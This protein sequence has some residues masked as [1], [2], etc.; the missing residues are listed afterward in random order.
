MSKHKPDLSTLVIK[1]ALFPSSHAQ[2]LWPTFKQRAPRLCAWL[3]NS[4]GQLYAHDSLVHRCTALEHMLIRQAGF[5]PNQQQTIGAGMALIL[6]LQE[7]FWQQLPA[8]DTFWLVELTHISP[9]REGANLLPARLLAL[10]EDA[11]Q[12]LYDSLIPYIK[13]TP[14]HFQ[15]LTERH[16]LLTSEKALPEP[17][18]TPELVFETTV[19]D[20]W[21]TSETGRVW[22]QWANEIQMLW[23]N[24]PINLERQQRQQPTVNTLWLMGGVR[25]AQL[26]Q[27]NQNMP[28]IFT[29]L[30]S[31][32]KTQD[33]QQWLTD[34]HT[35]D[36][37]IARI[38][39]QR[40]VLTGT[41][42]Y[43]VTEQPK[44]RHFLKR[45]FSSDKTGQEC[46]LN[47]F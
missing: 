19:Q 24:H 20:W 23:F 11:S 9:G 6:A 13:D 47:P 17:S 35:V 10:S 7:G 37:E 29:A 28:T 46:W 26:K 33:W 22:R 1:D 30:E 44:T 41:E 16:W 18:A 39:P 43:L 12:A 21:D 42:G 14:F 5:V 32:F 25:K 34:V 2:A 3:Q 8:T 36:E 27:T 15:P 31:S 40:I 45:F 38:S 4:Q